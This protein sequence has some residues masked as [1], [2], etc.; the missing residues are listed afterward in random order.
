MKP[1]SSASAP[2]L[3]VLGVVLA[4]A[5]SGCASGGDGTTDAGRRDGG[6]QR[7]DGGLDAGRDGGSD[8]GPTC[9]DDL[10]CDDGDAC[11]GAERC[12]AMRC[13][14]GTPVDCDDGIACTTDTCDS[15]DG[16]CASAPDDALCDGADLCDPIEGCVAPPPCTTD[17]DCDDLQ[18]CNGLETCD[19]EV[20]CRRSAMPTCDDGIACTVDTCDP[21]ANGGAGGCVSSADDARCDDGRACNGRERCDPTSATGCVSGTPIVCDDSLACT[22]DRCEDP[23]GTCVHR[24]PDVDGDGFVELGCGAGNDCNDRS[25]SI[26]PAAIELCDGVDNDC[27][28]IADDGAGMECV[29]GS[30]ARGCTTACGTAGNRVCTA[31]CTLTACAAA[32][33]SCN[34]C[35]DD[36][37]GLVDDGLPCRRGTTMA[38]TT[39]CGTT[40]TRVCAADCGGF[41][42]CSAAEVC[43]GCDDDGNGVADNGFTCV[44][45]ASQS[46][47]T[48]CGTAG[49]QTCNGTCTG[50]STCVAPSEV[51]SNGCDDNGNG[52][53]DEGCCPDTDINGPWAFGYEVPASRRT[54]TA[55]TPLT[56]SDDGVASIPIGFSFPFFGTPFTTVTVAANGFL[57]FSADP[58][59]GCCS[60]TA[61]PSSGAPP[62]LVAGF[63]D[64]LNPTLGGTIRYQTL[65]A[66]PSRELVVEYENIQHFGGGNP[67]T[68]QIVLREADGAAEVVCVRCPTDGSAHTQ[69]VQN[70]TRTAGYALP[71]RSANTRFGLIGDA[72][73][74]VTGVSTGPDG[75]CN[76]TDPCPRLST[77][78]AGATQSGGPRAFARPVPA[79]ART[80][81]APTSLTLA[82]DQV[83]PAIALPFPFTFF[84]NVFSSVYVS[85][86][87]FVT[88]DATTDAGCCSGQ[89][90]PTSTLYPANLIALFWEDL[91]PSGG[92]TI[93][94]Q[95]LGTAPNREWVLDFAS[96][97]HYPSGN[98]VTLQ[99]VLRET[100]NEAEILCVSCPTDGGLHTQG[101]QNGTRSYGYAVTGRAN[102]SFALTNDAVVYTTYAPGDAN[103]CTLP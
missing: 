29:F 54:F 75:L 30:G 72:V 23:A 51:C 66:A 50:F 25:P 45:G 21:A 67:V 42:A 93:R 65:G 78:P 95:V 15:T 86:N 90:L 5:A 39:T 9:A 62:N 88:F 1:I 11:N 27:T 14:D 60:G 82:D 35:D 18:A 91:N 36:G 2:L 41:G 83:S 102:A 68:M 7:D 97:P 28:G 96:V 37:D 38:C 12:V 32:T 34:D 103:V 33:E 13:T 19:P 58:G 99:L 22:T 63:W 20:G 46:C 98:P 87:G 94:H 89:L 100:T 44:R 49:A 40:G 53:I 85:S 6:S 80:L 77:N 59:G 76:T 31:A 4:L 79:A 64:D 70:A 3:G 16:S 61:L 8:A 47:I 92:G 26:N 56:L 101:V 48:A 52:A 81:T 55:A 24:G 43:N 69:G 17:A 57:S 84:G 10:E 74:Y 73:R 71:G